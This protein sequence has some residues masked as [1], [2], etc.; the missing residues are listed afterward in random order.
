MPIL[1]Q[2][3]TNNS[4]S[5][6]GN[7]HHESGSDPLP[8]GATINQVSREPPPRLGDLIPGHQL[9]PRAEACELSETQVRSSLVR[10]ELGLSQPLNLTPVQQKAVTQSHVTVGIG[11]RS[12]PGPGKKAS[13]R[14]IT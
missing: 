6:S 14:E 2:L 8:Q 7:W 11:G 1:I 4:S 12:T 3:P 13:S 10:S 5:P 9:V